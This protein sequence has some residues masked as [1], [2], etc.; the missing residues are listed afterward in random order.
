[1]M[2]HRPFTSAAAATPDPANPRFVPPRIPKFEARSDTCSNFIMSEQ[3]LEQVR[4]AV[5]G[6]I[7]GGFVIVT[8]DG[9]ADARRTLRASVSLS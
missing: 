1:M 7:V 6:Q 4:D 3:L 5:E 8:L 9:G 2:P